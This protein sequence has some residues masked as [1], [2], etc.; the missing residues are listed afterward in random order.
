V[1]FL[2]KGSILDKLHSYG[3]LDNNTS[4]VTEASRMKKVLFARRQMRRQG[5]KLK[6]QEHCGNS[7]SIFEMMHL[8]KKAREIDGLFVET[9]KI[10]TQGMDE[11]QLIL[12]HRK[13]HPIV[14]VHH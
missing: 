9:H 7:K 3:L 13:D 5:E 14:E 2:E 4:D 10:F 1:S 6:V 11:L 12:T 8:L